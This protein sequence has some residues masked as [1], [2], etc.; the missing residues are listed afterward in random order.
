MTRDARDIFY[1]DH[2]VQGRTVTNGAT[3]AEPDR[4]QD[5]DV[6]GEDGVRFTVIPVSA[7]FGPGGGP[8]GAAAWSVYDTAYHM[9]VGIMRLKWYLAWR[10]CLYFNAREET[11]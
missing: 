4:R 2:I 1:R 5:F 11:A 8:G 7:P 10:D 9:R 6:S 3:P